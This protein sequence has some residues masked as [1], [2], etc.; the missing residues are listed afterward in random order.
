MFEPLSYRE[1]MIKE[2]SSKLSTKGGFSRSTEKGVYQKIVDFTE[3]GG[4]SLPQE[5]VIS[6]AERI[7]RIIKRVS[8]AVFLDPNPWKGNII[9]VSRGN[10]D[11]ELRIILKK[12]GGIE[13]C[14]AKESGIS[15]SEANNIET[16]LELHGDM[17]INCLKKIE[18][19]QTILSLK[20]I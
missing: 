6:N 15:T 7:D 8:E 12:H 11:V 18:K 10:P 14:M 5:L 17:L 9:F 4:T 13:L 20:N 3:K 19:T 16:F 2:K 1:R